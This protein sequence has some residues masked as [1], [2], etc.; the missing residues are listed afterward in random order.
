MFFF[1]HMIGEF[2]PDTISPEGFKNGFSFYLKKDGAA[3]LSP[4]CREEIWRYSKNVH[5]FSIF[6]HCINGFFVL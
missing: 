4:Q 5:V 6:I 1:K 2:D 3:F